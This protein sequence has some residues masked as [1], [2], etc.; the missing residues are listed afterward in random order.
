MFQ[1]SGLVW[2]TGSHQSKKVSF[3]TMTQTANNIQATFHQRLYDTGL[4]IERE[5]GQVLQY[6]VAYGPLIGKPQFGLFVSAP[7]EENDQ[8]DP[9]FAED[10]MPIA[11]EVPFEP[12]LEQATLSMQEARLLRDF[13]NHPEVAALLDQE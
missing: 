10:E 2:K 3:Q 11:V 4:Q 8:D 13:L 7:E 5:N 6:S 12:N 9:R 1:S